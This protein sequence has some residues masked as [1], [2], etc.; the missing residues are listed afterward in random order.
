MSTQI[1]WCDEVWNPTTGC[2][3]ISAGCKYCYAERMAN[4]LQHNPKVKQRYRNGFKLTLQ[5]DSLNLPYTWKKPRRVFVN[6]MSDLFHVDVPFDYIE[7]VFEVIRNNPQH[8]FQV[9]TKRSEQLK[10]LSGF[11]NWPENLWMGVSVES[12]D[13][14]Y[15]GYHLQECIGPKTKFISFEPLIAS[16]PHLY[17]G[18]IDWIILGGESGH[19]A[20]LCE[21]EWLEKLAYLGHKQAVKVFVKQLGTH[22]AKQYKLKDRKGGN[23]DEWPTSFEHLKIREFPQ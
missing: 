11:L 5:P 10:M 15:R 22:L 4:R 9:L 17:L 12:D 1:Q 21:K 3:K 19:K 2:D 6:S 7:Y 14:K 23:W 8:I 16:I 20:R 13:F 18:E